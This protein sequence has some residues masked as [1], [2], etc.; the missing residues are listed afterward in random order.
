MLKII[1]KP[2]IYSNS[3]ITLMGKQSQKQKKNLFQITQ[4]NQ[5]TAYSVRP[6]IHDLYPIIIW[7]QPHGFPCQLPYGE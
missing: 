3:F 7:R 6:G 2:T 4:L 5:S 1:R